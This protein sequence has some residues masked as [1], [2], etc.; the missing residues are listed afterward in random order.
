VLAARNC[1]KRKKIPG[2]GA[3]KWTKQKTKFW[4]VATPL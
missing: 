1:K 2:D 3:K 4:A